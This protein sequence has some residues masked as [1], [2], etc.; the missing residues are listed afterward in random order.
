MPDSDNDMSIGTSAAAEEAR[1]TAAETEFR[2]S[3]APTPAEATRI[4]SD[5][6]NAGSESRATDVIDAEVR[7]LNDPEDATPE[8]GDI[9]PNVPGQPAT[10]AE[11][12]DEE[13]D[14]DDDLDPELGFEDEDDNFPDDEPALEDVDDTT[15]GLFENPTDDGEEAGDTQAD[16]PATE[17]AETDEPE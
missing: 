12:V 8:H 13:T 1:A 6:A 5:S 11:P 2:S 15:P 7:G 4:L 3:N 17:P 10:E 14:P 9:T 16:E